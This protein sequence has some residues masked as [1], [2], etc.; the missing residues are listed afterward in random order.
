MKNAFLGLPVNVLQAQRLLVP[1][2]DKL[3]T[4]ET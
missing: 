2:S 1:G 3:A 4:G